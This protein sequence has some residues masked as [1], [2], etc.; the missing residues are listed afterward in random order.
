MRSDASN[1]TDAGSEIII[2]APRES[3]AGLTLDEKQD[4]LAKMSG[5]DLMNMTKKDDSNGFMA[6]LSAGTAILIPGSFC[7]VSVSDDLAEANLGIKWNV[8][9]SKFRLQDAK[10]FLDAY[11]AE[12][13]DVKTEEVTKVSKL[14]CESLDA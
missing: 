4:S 9:G 2:G 3:L 13:S 10:A 12:K 6:R 5:S 8:M 1:F 7:Y 14:V 11:Q